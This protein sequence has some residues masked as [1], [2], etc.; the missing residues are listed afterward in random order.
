[1]ILT[2]LL[3]LLVIA[4]AFS[5][6]AVHADDYSEVNQL[7]RAGKMS[8]AQSKADQYLATKPRDPQMRFIK[9]VIQRETGKVSEAI[10]T[11]TK[12]TE[13]YPELPEPYN[14]LAVLYASQNQFDK[15][16]SALE[17]AIRTNPSYATAHENLGDVYARLASQAYNKALQLDGNNAAV[18]PKMALIR[19][20]FNPAAKGQRPTAS[21]TAAAKAEPAAAKTAPV[22]SNPAANST[23]NA[24]P[25]TETT[26]KTA[27]PN[28]TE[29]EVHAAVQAWARAWAA[30]DMSSY[31]A[32]YGKAF[33]PP[34][35]QSRSAW[36][37]ER[38]KRIIGK[39]SISVRLDNLKVSI[40]GT[41]AV[42]KF[43]QEYKADSL[44]ASSRKTLDLVKTGERWLI[45]RESTGN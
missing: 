28:T 27:T 40:E 37:E 25:A 23:S 44:S 34:G 16:R 17:L 15:A 39:K 8:D 19:E 11:F 31:L 22:N 30:K 43:K 9:G 5:I 4:T 41:T 33:D 36:E 20:L 7:I 14:N 24:A 6:T 38:R 29:T 10:S 12:L 35:A 2:S 32:A 26:P 13:D 45:I 1:M 21:V 42:A 18:P 3:R